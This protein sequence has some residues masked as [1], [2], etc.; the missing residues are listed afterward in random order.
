VPEETVKATG[1]SEALAG[2]QLVVISE[3]VTSANIGSAFAATRVGVVVLEPALFDDMAMTGPQDG[4]D[5]GADAATNKLS[6]VDGGSALAAG[7]RGDVEVSPAPVRMSWGAPGPAALR[8]AT[9][10]GTQGRWAIFAYETGAGLTQGTAPARRVGLFL[11]TEAAQLLNA[12]GAALFEAAARWASGERPVPA[13]VPDAG[14][15]D[16]ATGR[17]PDGS[18]RGG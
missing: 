5:Y 9:L 11:H 17:A 3:T 15:P 4:T 12:A 8:V 16:A 14:R 10:A 2:A 18:R 13:P 7:L 1:A 6:I